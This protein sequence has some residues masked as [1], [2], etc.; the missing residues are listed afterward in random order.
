MLKRV[1]YTM[2]AVALFV[3]GYVAGTVGPGFSLAAPLE[4]AAQPNC[5]TFPETRQTVCGRFLRYW[6]ENGGLRQ[7]GYPISAEFR[8]RSDLNG[9]TYTVQYFERAVFELHPE[10][11]PPNDVLLSQLGTFEYRRKYTAGTPPPAGQ[12]PAPVAPPTPTTLTQ[13]LATTDIE[14]GE[15]VS[16]N[17]LTFFVVRGD[18]LPRRVDVTYRL[19]NETNAPIAVSLPVSEQRLTDQDG[20]VFPARDPSR[21]SNLTLAPGQTFEN[22]TTFDADSTDQIERELI[23][24]INV[25]RIGTVRV[26]LR[27]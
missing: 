2:V 19:K 8:E 20:R 24:T 9:Q 1:S 25:P 15:T 10:N 22:G 17:G 16:R 14:V 7:Q 4:Q 6:Q 18:R 13:P 26:T 21:V 23:F 12:T 27:P 5:Q 3:G 11:Q